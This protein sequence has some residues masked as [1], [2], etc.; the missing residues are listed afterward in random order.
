MQNTKLA[1]TA[2]EILHSRLP[3]PVLSIAILCL[4]CQSQSMYFQKLS[5]AY[6]YTLLGGSALHFGVCFAH[7]TPNPPTHRNLN[8]TFTPFT[9]VSLDPPLLLDCNLCLPATSLENF[10]DQRLKSI[11]KVAYTTMIYIK[12]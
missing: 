4:K 3:E 2:N 6:P 5:G 1:C 12:N 10:L 8:F 9:R 7:C 11:D